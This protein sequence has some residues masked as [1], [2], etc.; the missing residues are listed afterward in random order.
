MNPLEAILSAIVGLYKVIKS[1]QRMWAWGRLVFGMTFSAVTA[2][3]FTCGSALVA[4]STFLFALGAGLVSAASISWVLFLRSP[5]TKG[6]MASMPQGLA[7]KVQETDQT[8]VQ[9]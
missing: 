2:G 4:G 9:K 3:L 1:E 5:L 6:M 7:A 8:T